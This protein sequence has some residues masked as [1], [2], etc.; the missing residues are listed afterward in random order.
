MNKSNP[1]GYKVCYREN[2]CRE[3]IRHFLTYTYNQAL[4]ARKHYRKYPQKSREDNHELKNPYWVIIPVKKSE[5]KDGI[6][7]EVPFWKPKGLFSFIT[8]NSI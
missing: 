7:H 6:W 8:Q 1:Y 2:G 5:V 4:Q 3:Y